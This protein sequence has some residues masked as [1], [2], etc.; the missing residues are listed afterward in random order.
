MT[1]E[2]GV[3][4][5]TAKKAVLNAGDLQ[6][7]LANGD[8]T[9]KAGRLAKDIDVDHALTWSG[10]SRLTLDAQR[11][12]I[13]NQQVTVIGKGA[14]TVTTNDGARNK[15][16]EFVIVLQHGGVQFW[17]L[18]SKLIIDDYRYTLVG[19][20]RTLGSDIAAN[21]SGFYALAKPYNANADGDYG[22]SP[23][24]DDFSGT[25]EGLGNTIDGLRVSQW[26]GSTG[27]FAHIYGGKVRD[28]GLNDA[29]VAT[30][31]NSGR[32]YGTGALVGY[33]AGTIHNCYAT[34]VV[35]ARISYV[36]GLVGVNP[37]RIDGSWAQV[38]VK[39]GASAGGLAGYNADQGVIAESY[40][41]GK[42]NGEGG[43][44][45][46]LVGL[47]Y[48]G[49]LADTYSTGLVSS[50][51]V[52]GGVIGHDQGGSL[53]ADYWDLDT[54]GVT[55]PAQGA[56][57]IPNDPGLVGLS[58]AQLKSGLP[59]GFSSKIWGQSP[60]INNGYP[61]LLANPPR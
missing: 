61:Y 38:S 2:A 34:G 46:G 16:G 43:G 56:G 17:D 30:L 10:N 48:P 18:A 21:P 13:V 52:I 28:L 15:D 55:D 50:S 29:D 32:A 5:E 42:V 1:C 31:Q 47:T 58:D 59:D 4:T 53:A 36:G 26:Q 19:N 27:L 22:Y 44:G 45:G 40:A 54:S 20:L 35:H 9:V 11:S 7:M 41:T 12:V 60:D 25:F 24:Y 8:A 33:N 23:V 6:T 57:N 39:G 49:T 3:C 14:L 37:G 51:N